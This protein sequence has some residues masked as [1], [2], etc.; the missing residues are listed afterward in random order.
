MAGKG[1]QDSE[2]ESIPDVRRDM[3]MTPN[4]TGDDIDDAFSQFTGTQEQKY[5]E[6]LKW[7]GEQFTNH[8]R[9]LRT[10]RDQTGNLRASIG[11]IIA[12]DGNVVH[13]DWSGDPEGISQGKKTAQTVLNSSKT[14]IVLIGVA[15]MQYAS[16]VESRGLDVITGGTL[17]AEKI[18]K[19]IMNKI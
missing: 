9:D 15:G 8:C 1:I 13:E 16:A 11:F 3:G 6:T 14:G 7:V 19:G 2:H 5:V 17:V 12:I 4:F 18:L 10:Y